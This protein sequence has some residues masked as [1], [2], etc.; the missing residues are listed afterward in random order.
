MAEDNSSYSKST[1]DTKDMILGRLTYGKLVFLCLISLAL[2][3]VG[4]LS[5]FAPLPLTI[6]FLLYGTKKTFGVV[7]AATI[8]T[9][10][11]SMTSPAMTEFAYYGV[12]LSIASL[13]AYAVASIIMKGENPVNGLMHRGFIV[14]AIVGS[15]V[16]ISAVLTTG[17]MTENIEAFTAKN[18][19]IVKQ[20]EGYKQIIQAGGEQARVLEEV[21]NN[22]K[23]IL[24]QFYQWI[25]SAVFVGT[26]FMLW[27]TLFMILRNG[28]I[29]KS[30]HNYEYDL[31]D[32]VKFRV[33]DFFAYFVVVGLA[34][35]LGGEYLGGKTLEIIGGNVLYCLGVFYFFQGM[36]I[37]LDFLK[38]L[39]V[40]GLLRNL[41]TVMTI[42]FAYRIVAIVGLFDLWVEFRK[43]FKKN[44]GD[45]S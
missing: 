34:L 7:A 15:L 41:L 26:F 38:H 21:F 6:A 4:P 43:Y 27:I 13:M 32:L 8:L 9:V 28:T 29:W 35:F 24:T 11:A 37:Y 44:E 31:D 40:T 33:P 2:S 19:E 23:V 17:S 20:N 22:P 25:F 1:I 42:F 18:F 30:I 14:L 12:I 16:L 5:F 39:K 45:I 3:V 36:G 10:V